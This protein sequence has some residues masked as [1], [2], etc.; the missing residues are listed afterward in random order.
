M[1]STAKSDSENLEKEYEEIQISF[2]Q[3]YEGVQ[4]DRYDAI[5]ELK[6]SLAEV[7]SVNEML[8]QSTAECN[9][10]IF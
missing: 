1:L 2:E 9:K 7:Q 5:Q 6:E 10:V 3:V 8:S 4:L